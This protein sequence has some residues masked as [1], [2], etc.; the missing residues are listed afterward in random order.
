MNKET[1]HQKWWKKMTVYSTYQYCEKML[2]LSSNPYQYVSKEEF[3]DKCKEYVKTLIDYNNQGILAKKISEIEK[4]SPFPDDIR[5]VLHEYT[6]EGIFQPKHLMY[7][8]G[9]LEMD[10]IRFEFLIE[11]GILESD[12]EI[13]YGIKA[14]S[15]GRST[16]DDFADYVYEMSEKWFDYMREH[17][18]TRNKP[19]DV[20]EHKL[21]NNVH[22]GTFWISWLRMESKEE[23]DDVVTKLYDRIYKHF[24]IFLR[25]DKEYK[26]QTVRELADNSG[27]FI[28][29]T[30]VQRTRDKLN[31]SK[32]ATKILSDEKVD[33]CIIRR[34]NTACN[35]K[36]KKGN[37]LFIKEDNLYYF[38][39][40]NKDIVVF[41]NILTNPKHFKNAFQIADDRYYPKKD[42]S[43]EAG[44]KLSSQEFMYKVKEA[45]CP[46][47]K[48]NN[49]K[50][51]IPRKWI[52][53][54]FRNKNGGRI[55][56][57]WLTQQLVF[58]TLNNFNN[59]KKMVEEYNLIEWIDLNV[60]DV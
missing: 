44:K 55:V 37:V 34:L 4:L 49:S 15:N 39:C 27:N 53:E 58:G 23:F 11:Y 24:K 2:A 43:D 32:S 13:Y 38:K 17:K 7:K 51:N 20:N 36:D 14:I 12:V 60:L 41:I 6:G 57:K 35:L 30:N 18:A 45:W 50:K 5:G 26:D 3:E 56:E 54:R 52:M 29:A 28:I 40:S 16:N 9:C 31:K 46:S 19:I 47:D 48:K 42:N 8:L 21:T 10:D 22:N 1:I 59:I 25:K 33:E